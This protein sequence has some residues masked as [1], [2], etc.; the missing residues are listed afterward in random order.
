MSKGFY[1]IFDKFRNLEGEMYA[2]IE[3]LMN[4]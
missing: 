1:Q 3:S 4:N 2:I